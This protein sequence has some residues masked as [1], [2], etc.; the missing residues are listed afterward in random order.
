MSS[1][2]YA[3]PKPP[4]ERLQPISPLGRRDREAFQP[5]AIARHFAYTA[6]GPG[7]V[8]PA[9]VAMRDYA[10][11]LAE[12]GNAVDADQPVFPDD[13]QTRYSSLVAQRMDISP[14]D[15][16]EAEAFI[17]QV[18][19]I[20]LASVKDQFDRSGNRDEFIAQ[21]AVLPLVTMGRYVQGTLTPSQVEQWYYDATG[22]AQG[23]AQARHG[24]NG[25]TLSARLDD[26]LDVVCCFTTDMCPHKV[27]RR[28]LLTPVR[29]PRSNMLYD[30]DPA[31]ARANGLALLRVAIVS[32]LTTIEA[33]QQSAQWLFAK[34]V[35][36]AK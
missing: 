14:S 1:H 35:I 27:I 6:G 9:R 7:A 18:T 8:Y 2:E 32:E 29:E 24:D 11:K 31:R 34:Q 30:V 3:K 16:P 15:S 5:E 20:D 23:Y 12:I 26:D 33:E 28:E 22:L 21:A 10:A 4:T 36:T 25:C 17:E 19:M 13:L